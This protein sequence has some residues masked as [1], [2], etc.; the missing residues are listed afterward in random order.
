MKVLIR[1]VVLCTSLLVMVKDALKVLR[2]G[3]LA[4]SELAQEL[5][6]SRVQVLIRTCPELAD[7]RVIFRGLGALPVVH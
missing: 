5:L 3:H 7:V 1:L 4:D 6:G 2:L